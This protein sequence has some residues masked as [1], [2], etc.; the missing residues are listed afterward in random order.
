MAIGTGSQGRFKA[1]S[2]PTACV[3]ME[4]APLLYLVAE[5]DK[6]EYAFVKEMRAVQQQLKPHHVL[7]SNDKNVSE[8]GVPLQWREWA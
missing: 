7:S 5:G 2:T 1:P 6:A 3:S 4:T 8:T